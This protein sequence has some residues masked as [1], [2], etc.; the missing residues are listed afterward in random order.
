MLVRV[1]FLDLR[2]TETAEHKS[3]M[4][5][6]EQVLNHGRLVMGPEIDLF[7]ERVASYCGRRHCVSVGSGTD[8]LF[9]GLKALG[10]GPGD[11]VITTS[12]SWIATANAIAL[13]GATPVFA[14]IS[15]D[16]NI[17]PLSVQRLI[18][19]KTKAILVVD[20][21]GRI[22]NMEAL[23]VICEKHNLFLVEDGSQAF[24]ALRAGRRCGSFGILSAISHNPMKLLAA[25]GEAGSIL[26]DNDELAERL[27]IL[28]YNGTINRETCIEP[29]LNGRM[30]TLQASIL[31]CRLNTVKEL[32]ERRRANAA[33]YL[34]KLSGHVILPFDEPDE[35]QVFY[36]FTIQTH[37]RDFLERRLASL[38]IETKVQHRLPMPEHPAYKP[39][40]G[41]FSNAIKLSKNI[42]A[43]PVHEKL[44]RDQC[45]FV[46]ESVLASLLKG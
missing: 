30:D 23:I 7:E 35:S 3:L 44:T 21:T 9:I 41:E 37:K 18:T 10:L 38:G 2:V 12:L 8:A 32:I 1:P 42:L 31:L 4:Q 22:P 39:A 6:V 24:G 34:E 46:V 20:Y 27:R 11:E 33:Y 26:C 25:I 5:A 16:L 40:R 17:N 19:P 15:E 45:E 28:R 13:T 43:L 29:S 14:D 36:T